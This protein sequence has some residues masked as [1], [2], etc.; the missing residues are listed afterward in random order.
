[1][2]TIICCLGKPICSKENS[3]LSIILTCIHGS[4]FVFPWVDSLGQG[5]LTLR[6]QSKC[7]LTCLSGGRN[8]VL[9]LLLRYLF[10]HVDKSHIMWHMA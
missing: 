9:T 6:N 3:D 2:M 1:M 10:I 5:N 8:L 4:I 7:G